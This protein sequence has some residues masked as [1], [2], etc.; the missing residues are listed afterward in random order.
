MLPRD[1]L[2]DICQY[3]FG[4]EQSRQIRAFLELIGP[5]DPAKLESEDV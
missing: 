4:Q 2:I 3:S 1:E 5:Y